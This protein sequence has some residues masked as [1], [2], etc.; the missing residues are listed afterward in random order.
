MRVGTE[1]EDYGDV[2]SSHGCEFRGRDGFMRGIGPTHLIH[3]M[4][5]NE[6]K[7]IMVRGIQEGFEDTRLLISW[8]S[9]LPVPHLTP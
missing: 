7:P 4:H 2:L 1:T 9:E 6:N 8:R 5:K 3:W